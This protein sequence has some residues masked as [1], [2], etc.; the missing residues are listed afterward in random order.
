MQRRRICQPDLGSDFVER[1][2]GGA[3]Q[4]QSTLETHAS[5]ELQWTETDRL[6]GAPGQRARAEAAPASQRIERMSLV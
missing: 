3:Q 4:M 1:H 6:T 5:H 2:S